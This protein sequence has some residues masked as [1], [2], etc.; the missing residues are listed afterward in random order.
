MDGMLP[1]LIIATSRTDFQYT[2]EQLLACGNT[3]LPYEY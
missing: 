3:L 1:R 2:G